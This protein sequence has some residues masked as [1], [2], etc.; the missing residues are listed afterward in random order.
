MLVFIKSKIIEVL[1]LH[2]RSW[3]QKFKLFHKEEEV[4]MHR[5]NEDA[6]EVCFGHSVTHVGT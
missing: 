2:T 5:E 4:G 1:P 6:R 3:E